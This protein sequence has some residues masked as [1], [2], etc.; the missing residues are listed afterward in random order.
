MQLPK[1]DASQIPG[2]ETA[3]GIFGSTSELSVAAPDDRVVVLMVYLYD[4]VPPVAA[5]LV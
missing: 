1:I 3:T 4:T 5:A 2:L